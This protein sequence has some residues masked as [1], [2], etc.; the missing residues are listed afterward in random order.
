MIIFDLDGNPL[1]AGFISVPV[2]GSK[3]LQV[4]IDCVTGLVLQMDAVPDITIEAKQEDQVTFTD[5]VAGLA[6]STWNG[7]REIFDIKITAGA[8]APY[9]VRKAF[10]R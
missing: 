2:S 4:M 1:P 5:L 10:L 7:S 9:Q 3:Q 8:V 6:L